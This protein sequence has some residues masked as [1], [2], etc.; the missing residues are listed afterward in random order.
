MYPCNYEAPIVYFFF[1]I[2]ISS[3]CIGLGCTMRS[4][5][6]VSLIIS[7]PPT[8]RI[9]T[10]RLYRGVRGIARPHRPP[11]TMLPL[12]LMSRRIKEIF[13]DLVTFFSSV[14]N[15]VSEQNKNYKTGFRCRFLNV[16]T[17]LCTSIERNLDDTRK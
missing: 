13:P 6:F 2:L 4:G 7:P 9:Q 8:V 1:Y 15:S 16:T 17:R 10:N 5:S 14:P 3:H 12:P 11:A